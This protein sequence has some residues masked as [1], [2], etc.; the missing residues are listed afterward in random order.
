[1][2]SDQLHSILQFPLPSLPLRAGVDD[3]GRIQ[4]SPRDHE[5]NAHSTRTC[6]LIAPSIGEVLALLLVRRTAM[7]PSRM[8]MVAGCAVILLGTAP[9][10]FA[11]R[12]GGGHFGGGGGGGGHGGGVAIGRGG[13][14]AGG[15]MGRGIRR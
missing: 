7:K 13:G 5:R 10:A 1:M 2:T 9:A 3:P 12:G 14:W 6:L 8:L 4:V 15:P 11:Q